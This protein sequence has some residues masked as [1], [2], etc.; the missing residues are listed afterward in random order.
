MRKLFFILLASTVLMINA[1]SE[2]KV[3]EPDPVKVES[4]T[5]SDFAADTANKGEF[6]FFSF[7]TGAIVPRTDSATV[8]WDIA[9]S[10]T[11]IIVNSG[12]RGPGTTGVLLLK[13][14]DFASLK[15][16]PV[17]GYK[18]ETSIESP[19]IPIGSGNGW[20]NYDGSGNPPT[21]KPIPGIVIVVK[22]SEGK[23]AKMRILS[24][25][26]GAPDV[27]TFE[28]LSKFYKFEYIY[29]PDGTRI[30]SE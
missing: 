20:Y 16:A 3:V 4:K 26:K 6:T 2:D 19:A 8:N 27:I 18:S 29:Q 5:V 28:T 12:V 21:I 14:T 24:Y 22:T 7:K 13:N 10:K 30:F 23:Y 15:E 11:I 17:D 1:C 25:Y 9:F